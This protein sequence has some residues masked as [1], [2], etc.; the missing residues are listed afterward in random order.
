LAV[1]GSAEPVSLLLAA[2]GVEGRSSTKASEGSFVA[3]P[4]G[5]FACGDEQC[6]GGVGADTEPLEHLG[7]GRGDQRSEDGVER[8]EFLVEGEDPASEAFEC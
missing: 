1:T 3:D 6:A 8:C 2:G 4:V 7:G 5:V